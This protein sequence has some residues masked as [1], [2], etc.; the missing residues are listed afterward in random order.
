MGRKVL[1]AYSLKGSNRC[2]WVL[3]QI[4]PFLII[5]KQKALD[6]IEELEKRPF[7][8]WANATEES[9]IKQSDMMKRIWK[10]RKSQKGSKLATENKIQATRST[11]DGRG[12]GGA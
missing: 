2:Y 4:L 6:I 10:E 5:K 8:R 11:H 1:Y 3:R 12:S 7:G 9:R